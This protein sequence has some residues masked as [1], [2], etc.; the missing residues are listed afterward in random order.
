MLAEHA[1][2]SFTR[3]GKPLLAFILAAALIL[4]ACGQSTP[5]ATPNAPSAGSA[6]PTSLPATISSDGTLTPRQPSAALALNADGAS[7]PAPL[8]QSWIAAYKKVVPNLTIGYQST[9]SGQGIKDFTNGLTDF[10]ATD[11][12]LSDEQL[13]TVPDTLHIP[14]VLGAVV[15][16]Y[17]L[18]GIRTLKLSPETLTGIYQGVIKTWN[19]PAIAADN[20]GV[21]LPTLPI[22][23]VYRSD[24]SGTTSI[25]TS[26]LSS[27]S[28]DWKGAVGSGTAVKWPTGTGAP[29]N[30]GIAALV[31]KTP[32]AIG[33]VELIYAFTQ[34]PP[35]PVAALRNAAG[36]FVLPSDAS[37][38]AAAESFSAQMPEDLRLS[39]VNPP[40]RKDAYPISGFT[41]LLVHKQMANQAKA[42]AL[43][44]FLYWSLTSG[45]PMAQTLKY[46]ALPE[47][48][49]KRA[50]QL[51]AT[52]TSNGQPVFRLPN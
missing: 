1:P 48:V 36:A 35:L 19:D 22:V 25:F 2:F 13:K 52:I 33:Y 44:D 43:T 39:I 21:Q 9:G 20:Q 12:F 7:F 31:A 26:Y 14:T 45:T 47:T 24:G 27:V 28:P 38:A 4:S 3:R 51:L 8:Y 42:E 5:A 40:E 16:I 18:D 23:V 34:N 15:L 46:V 37:I 49:R 32:G 41:Y 30:D 29:K 6:Q 10:G 11:A 50:I 17:N